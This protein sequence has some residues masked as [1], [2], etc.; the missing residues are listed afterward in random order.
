MAMANELPTAPSAGP[1][2]MAQLM[3]KAAQSEM[4][5]W[6]NTSAFGSVEVR[7]IVHA[8]EVGL[9]IGSER[10]DLRC[11][12]A[13]EL[14]A[15]AHNLQQQDL[16][17]NQVNFH[18]GFAFSNNTSSRGD[19]QPRSFAPR[20][21]ASPVPPVEPRGGEFTE[22]PETSSGVRDGINLLA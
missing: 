3:N 22:P 15:I 2:Q 14:P 4:R 13:N 16:R 19:W 17:L 9:L 11:L 12:L 6:L 10:G 1:V 5:I 8:N 20:P 21:A 7:T 18:Q